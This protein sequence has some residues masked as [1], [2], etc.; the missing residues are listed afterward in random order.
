M[1]F[2]VGCFPFKM[3]P[4]VSRVPWFLLFLLFW[5]PKAILCQ[6]HW[7]LVSSL[8]FIISSFWDFLFEK[9][10]LTFP[11]WGV[12]E[13]WPLIFLLSRLLDSTFSDP[14]FSC[15]SFCH[16]PK[17]ANSF[18]PGWNIPSHIPL[19]FFLLGSFRY[20]AFTHGLLV[21]KPSDP[22]SISLGGWY[23]H[24]Y[25]SS[26]CFLVPTLNCLNPNLALL[27]VP[28]IPGSW[29]SLGILAQLFSQAPR[30]SNLWG[31]S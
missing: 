2:T 6:Q 7:W 29:E 25:Y 23:G 24:I 9:P 11:F 15:F 17:W 16:F 28:R 3:H 4:R 31:L 14:T 10:Q 8:F 13:G 18:L 22:L 19:Q 5:V 1:P 20:Q 12:L 30:L 27:H 21:L 26:L